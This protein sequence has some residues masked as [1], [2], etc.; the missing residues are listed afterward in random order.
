MRRARLVF[1]LFVAVVLAVPSMASAAAPETADVMD[2]N[3]IDVFAADGASLVRQPNGA[4]ISVRI[5]APVPGQYVYPMGVTPGSPEVFTLWAFVFNHPEHCSF[6][7]GGDDTNNPD[8]EFGVYNVTGHV[9]AGQWLTMSGRFGV[10]DPA[11]APPGVT[12]HPLSNPGG[13][14][15]HVAITSHGEL[16]PATLPG[17]FSIP[18]GNP[19]CGCW[20]V[21]IFD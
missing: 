12:P 2:Q 8:V 15:F 9:N 19:G 18:T 17:E 5:P 6:P 20:W 16:D 3:G 13:A 10:G 1:A 4:R 14:E 11:G 7:C 21:A